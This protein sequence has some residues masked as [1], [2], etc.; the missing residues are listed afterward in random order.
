[1]FNTLTYTDIANMAVDWA[2]GSLSISDINDPNNPLAILCK[3]H[4]GQCIK[5]ELDKYEWVFARRFVRAV[6][7]DIGAYPEADIDGYIAYHLPQDFSRLSLYFFNVFYPYRTDQYQFG[8]NYF[9][10]SKYLYV[11]T[12]LDTLPYVSNQVP[13]AEWHS[14]FCDIASIALAERIAGKVQG[15]DANVEFLNSLYKNKK[16]DARKLEL[17]QM[18]A[19]PTGRSDSQQ[20]RVRFIGGII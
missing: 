14:L 3:R 11:R 16:R 17:L 2:G 9:L 13:I 8:F 15:L 19:K 12:K 20:A 10:T 5:A 18:E 4:I 7:V 1:M 6:P